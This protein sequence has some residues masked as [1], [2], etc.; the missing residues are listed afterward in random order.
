MRS[1]FVI[2]YPL[3]LRKPGG[4]IEANLRKPKTS[5]EGQKTENLDLERVPHDSILP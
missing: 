3:N 1:R 5:P 4:K 2:I